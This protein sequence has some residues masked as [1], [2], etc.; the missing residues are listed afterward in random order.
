MSKPEHKD[1]FIDYMMV[2]ELGLEVPDDPWGPVKEGAVTLLSFLLFGGIPLWVYTILW[3]AGYDNSSGIFGISCAATV[4]ALFA[5]GYGYFGSNRV[6][7][8][9]SH[10]CVTDAGHCKARL[11]G[12]PG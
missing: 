7:P 12:N 4:I 8:C 2:E 9:T 6:E 3:G 11:H 10:A 5:L 1:F